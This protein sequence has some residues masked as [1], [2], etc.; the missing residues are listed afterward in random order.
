MHSSDFEGE[1]KRWRE[2]YK[3]D[4]PK[5]GF[6]ILTLCILIVGICIAILK[7]LEAKDG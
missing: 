1:M 5:G 4:K 2:Q 7:R 3:D 6:M